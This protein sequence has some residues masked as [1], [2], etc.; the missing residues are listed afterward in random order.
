MLD[1][2]SYVVNINWS[3]PRT[4]LWRAVAGN[5]LTLTSQEIKIG[6][7][8]WPYR[9]SLCF[10]ATGQRLRSVNRRRLHNS[11]RLLQGLTLLR[12]DD[13]VEVIGNRFLPSPLCH[14]TMAIQWFSHFIAHTVIS[15]L[16]RYIYT[17][18]TWGPMKFSGYWLFTRNC[19]VYLFIYLFIYLLNERD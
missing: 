11:H 13:N 1:R 10:G 12:Q 5:G 4:L 2:C 15:L 7:H 19:T 3:W 17:Q 16:Y 14:H 8:Y 18:Q 6:A 9:T